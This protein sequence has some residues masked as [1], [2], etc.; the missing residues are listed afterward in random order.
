MA[1]DGAGRDRRLTRLFGVAVAAAIFS[2]S[3]MSAATAAAQPPPGGGRG[4]P[5]PNGQAGAAIDLTGYW[6]SVVTEDWRYRM[7]TPPKGE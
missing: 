4:A 3:S 5:P 1:S 7:V 6:V 2:M